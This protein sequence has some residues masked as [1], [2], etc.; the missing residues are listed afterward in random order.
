MRKQLE[1]EKLQKM[2]DETPMSADVLCN[3]LKSSQWPP[4]DDEFLAGEHDAALEALYRQATKVA[5][6]FG[7]EVPSREEFEARYKKEIA[8][9]GL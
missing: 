3:L 2:N 4:L 9:S 5:E 7:W 8:G 1:K 6:E